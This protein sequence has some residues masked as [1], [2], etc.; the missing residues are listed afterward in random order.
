MIIKEFAVE[1]FKLVQQL[2]DKSDLTTTIVAFD[3]SHEKPSFGEENLGI[4]DSISKTT[5]DSQSKNSEFNKLFQEFRVLDV[6]FQESFIS[7][8]E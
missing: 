7:Q 1:G 4:N 2:K 8:D 6:E 5:L 3:D